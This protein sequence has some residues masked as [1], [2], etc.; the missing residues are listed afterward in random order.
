[1]AVTVLTAVACSSGDPKTNWDTVEVDT[2]VSRSVIDAGGDFTVECVVTDANGRPVATNTAFQVTPGASV[3]IE[4]TK[5]TVVATGFY[6]VACMLADGTRKDETPETVLVTIG[7]AAKVETTLNP[8]TVKVGEEA[9]ANCLVKGVN[10]NVIPNAEVEIVVDPAE[11]MVVDGKKLRPQVVG[12]FDVACRVTGTPVVDP[13]PERLTVEQGVPARITAIIEEESIVAGTSAEV[14]CV[15]ADEQGNPL[16]METAVVPVAGLDIDGHTVTGSKAGTYQVTCATAEDFGELEVVADTL[17]VVAAT[18]ASLV[19]E[20]K[21]KKASYL[22]SDQVAIEAKVLDAYENVVDGETAT[23]EIPEGMALAGTKYGFKKEGRFL[24]KGT[25]DSNPSITGE[26]TLVCD[27]SGPVISVIKPERGAT[28]DGSASV[29]IEGTAIDAVSEEV[30]LKINNKS[31]PVGADGKFYHIVEAQHGLNILTFEATDGY[32][33]YTKVVQSF[34]YSTGWVDYETQVL[35]DVMLS[36]SLLVFLGQNFLDDGVHDPNKIDDLATLVEVLLA[37]LDLGMF[38]NPTTPIVSL[39]FPS[40]V[41][42][43]F[44]IAGVAQVQLIGDLTLTVFIE[45]IQLSGPAVTIHTRNGGLLFR[46]AFNG[47]NGAPG[48]MVATGIEL[49]F[50]LTAKAMFG[51]A[52]LFSAGLSPHLYVQSSLAVGQVI[53]GAS[54]D[55]HKTPGQ[56]LSLSIQSLDIGLEQIDLALLQDLVID[57]GS[58]SF[59]NNQVIDLPAIPLGNLV[60][61]INN[62]MSNYVLNPLLN[63]LETAVMDFI[64]PLLN[65]PISNLLEDVLKQLEIA[66]PLPLPQLPGASQAVTINFQTSLDSL[67]FTTDGGTVGLDTGFH[68][69]KGVERDVLGCILRMNCLSNAVPTLPEFNVTEK[70][71]LAALLD[72]VN[73]LFFAL[74]WGGG[75]GLVLDESVLGGVGLDG[76]GVTDLDVKLDFLLPPILDDCTAKMMVE[77]QIGDLLVTANLKMMGAPV[78]LVM[79]VSVALEANIYGDGDKIGIQILGITEIGT[80]LLEVQGNLLGVDIGD[81]VEGVLIPMLVE[82]VSNLTLDAFPIPEIDLGGLI[83]GVPAGTTLKLGNLN[84]GMSNGYLRIGG[85]LQ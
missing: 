63:F 3:T 60:S 27:G 55:I 49:H 59:N 78:K 21:P 62:L 75:L 77:V 25:L 64:L 46:I 13:T 16:P 15:V 80:Q 14:V 5:V 68:S 33:K 48:A 44:D 19:L 9:R 7:G 37:G 51:G 73:E 85:Q 67:V 39:P 31:V 42:Y 35:D 69:A 28:L 74:W 10:G 47:A 61:G 24:V 58:V 52:D 70:M 12:V 50:D 34:Y 2:V 4:G 29:D 40:V 79:Y 1:M 23:I 54:M 30:K 84:I 82:Q 26:L 71:E 65:G 72:M 81:M 6:D 57:L 38:V 36:Q 17:T 53:L 43:T 11:G 18:P 41:N 83:P 22:P 8:K 32:G 76:F 66:L 45:A 56:D 20:P